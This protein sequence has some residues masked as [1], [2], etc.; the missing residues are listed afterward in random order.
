MSSSGCGITPTDDNYRH[1]DWRSTARRRKLTVRDFQTSQS[2]RIIFMVDC[3]R[4]MTGQA[5]DFNLLDHA[6][7]A[8]LMLS[9]VALAAGRFRRA[10]LL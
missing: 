9:Y 3:G 6:F 2:Q 8:M 5:G 10:A 1:I 7:N 4:M